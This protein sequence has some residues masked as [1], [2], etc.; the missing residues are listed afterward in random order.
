MGDPVLLGSY[1]FGRPHAVC[2]TPSPI[3]VHAEACEPFGRA[4]A[5]PEIVR[6]RLVSVRAY[7]SED[8]YLYELGDACESDTSNGCSTAP[9]PTGARIA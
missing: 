3:L 6:N 8:M 2:W 5:V 4:D 1:H 7:D 9:S